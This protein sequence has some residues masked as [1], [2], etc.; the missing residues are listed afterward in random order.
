MYVITPKKMTKHP[1]LV[2]AV[3]GLATVLAAAGTGVVTGGVGR[4]RMALGFSGGGKTKG[5]SMKN[6]GVKVLITNRII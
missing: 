5:I 2:L 1:Q 4:A 3:A 6:T